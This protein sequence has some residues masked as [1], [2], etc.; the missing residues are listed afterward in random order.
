MY[1]TNQPTTFNNPIQSTV[2]QTYQQTTSVGG[3]TADPLRTN[4][5]LPSTQQRTFKNDMKAKFESIGTVSFIPIEAKFIHDNNI[6]GK[7]EPY[8]KFKVGW[9]SGKSSIAKNSGTNP[10]WS[11]EHIMIKVKENSSY[12]K[13]KVKDHSRS[14]FDNRLGVAEISLNEVFQNGKASQWVP[15][16]KKGITTGEVL[17][18]MVYTPKPLVQPIVK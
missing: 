5:G 4:P 15:I 11:G 17:L 7:M 18:E 2:T 9:R 6:L 3:M 12:A 14:M 10:V 8:C 1:Q 16:I 13:L